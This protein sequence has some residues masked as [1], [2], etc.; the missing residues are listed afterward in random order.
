MNSLYLQGAHIFW[1]IGSYDFFFL[2]QLNTHNELNTYIYYQL[3]PTCFGVCYTVFRETFAFVANNA[4][5]SL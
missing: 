4:N 1:Y 5:I 3:H 2:F